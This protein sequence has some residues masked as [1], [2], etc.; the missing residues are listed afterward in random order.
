[1]GTFFRTT[2]YYI[3]IRKFQKQ[4]KV[5]LISLVLVFFIIG[6][7]HDLFTAFKSSDKEMLFWIAL[8]KWVFI[9]IIL[10]FNIYYFK[11]IKIDEEELKR[12]NEKIDLPPMSQEVLNKKQIL[13][14]TDLIL[15]KYAKG[16]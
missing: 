6:L 2:T 5:L 9:S 3:L 14:T 15:K 10:F 13:T 11:R 16:E 7:H 12:F 1:M 4:L 8:G